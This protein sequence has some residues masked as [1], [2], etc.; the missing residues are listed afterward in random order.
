MIT[1]AIIPILVQSGTSVLPALFAGA[2]T[3]VVTLFR[4]FRSARGL[5]WKP[6]F[7]LTCAM[8]TILIFVG[9]GIIRATRPHS[10]D[11][12]DWAQVAINIIRRDQ[13]PKVAPANDNGPIHLRPLWE[14]TLPEASFLSTPVFKDNRLYGASCVVDVGATFGSVFCLDATTG[15]PIWQVEKIGN[16]NLKGIVSSPAVTTDGKYVLIGEG[17]HFDQA[18]HLIC[19]DARTGELHWKV[20]VPQNHVESSPALSNEFVVFPAQWDPKLGIHVT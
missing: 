15:Q 9:P 14:Y 17:L 11:R 4:P 3:F 7:I 1:P 5:L 16:E 2:G 19:L 18:C 6:S 12:T 10:R 8:V 13:L 20:D